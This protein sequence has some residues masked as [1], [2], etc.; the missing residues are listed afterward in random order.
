MDRRG[1]S[2]WEGL[3]TT[4]VLAGPGMLL[5][6]IPLALKHRW[7]KM[8]ISDLEEYPS[9][10]FELLLQTWESLGKLWPP[11]GSPRVIRKSVRN[12]PK[13]P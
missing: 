5:V 2:E 1:N 8:G 4:T 9:P 12:D 7:W 3:S 11:I 10:Y 6:F 13:I